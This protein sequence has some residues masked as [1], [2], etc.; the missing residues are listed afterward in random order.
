MKSIKE[1]IIG[2]K[3]FFSSY[4]DYRGKDLDMLAIMNHLINDDKSFNIKL[5]DKDIFMYPNFSKDKFIQYDLECNIPM[6]IGKY[7]V[8]EFAKYIK[9]TIEDLYQLK[10]LV[11][12][13][14]EKHDYEKII[15]DSYIANSGF[16]LTDE[17]REKAYLRYK[18]SR[19]IK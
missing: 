9:L 14:D 18:E 3:A 16:Y 19:N 2:S 8:P 12:K 5:K 6:R 17:Q 1:I 10:P 13:L 11:D 15:Y 4:N 7:L